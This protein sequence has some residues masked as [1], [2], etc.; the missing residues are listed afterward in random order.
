MK[1]M[2]IGLMGAAGSGKDT[3]RSILERE[4][5][6]C[7]LAFADPV[8]AMACALLESVGALGY[9]Q[10]RELKE[11]PVPGLGFSYRELA[12]TLGTEW[13][14]E[15]IRKSLWIDIAMA[16]IDAL[17]KAVPGAHVVVS[18][19]RFED[20]VEALRARGA[21]IWL[22]RRPSV[23]QVRS[24]VSESLANATELADV[25]IDNDG[26]LQDLQDKVLS[27]MVACT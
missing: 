19:V 27:A 13:G 1:S 6:F 17:H 10:Q 24:H 12:Q 3:V 16:R 2:L 8:R 9:A 26:T 14:R 25:V 5:G 20:E 21:A 23:A 22:V 15:T 7:G 4:F 18:D 11:L